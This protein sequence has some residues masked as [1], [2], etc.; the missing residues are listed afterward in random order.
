MSLTQKQKE[1]T[2]RIVLDETGGKIPV[3][4]GAI[5]AGTSRVIENIKALE[6]MGGKFVVVTPP[7]YNKI[8]SQNEIVTHFESI[9][10]STPLRIIMYNIP[11]YTQVDISLETIIRL[12]NVD[13]IVAIKESSG[14]FTK[15]L[16]C[17]NYFK[18]GCRNDFSVLQ[19]VTELAGASMLFGAD[20]C[21][22]VLAPVF[23]EIFLNLYKVSHIRNV[24]GV[25]LW[26]NVVLY[27]A[28]ILKIGRNPLSCIKYAVSLL[29]LC[30]CRVSEPW[31]PLSEMEKTHIEYVIDEIRRAV[32]E[33]DC[34]LK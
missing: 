15:M 17:L 34:P 30:S 19:G 31:E 8:Y 6:Q 22:P 14:S 23:P 4:C 33:M 16:E 32:Q 11:K 12:S 20:G 25:T 3:L 27:S 29:G 9:A 13:N 7:F 28:R 24:E 1:S 2:I 18:Q 5:D 26:Q 21:I 10:A